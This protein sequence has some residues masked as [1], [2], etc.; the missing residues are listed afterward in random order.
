MPT[1]TGVH[2]LRNTWSSLLSQL[3]DGDNSANNLFLSTS[4][5]SEINN[6]TVNGKEA[7]AESMECE[8]GKLFYTFNSISREMLV[9]DYG[10][11]ARVFVCLYKRRMHPLRVEFNYTVRGLR[12]CNVQPLL[13][14]RGVV[15]LSLLLSLI[16][17][18][19]KIVAYNF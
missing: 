16:S 5:S 15:I 4:Q 13:V 17:N 11:E 14:G 10:L 7:K 3:F 8:N 1:A 9:N 2:R 18:F 19:E 6:E 12:N